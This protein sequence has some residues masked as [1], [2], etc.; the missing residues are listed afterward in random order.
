MGLTDWE[1]IEISKWYWF[2]QFRGVLLMVR[3]FS[4]LVCVA[5]M[6]S[7]SQAALLNS[8]LL[9]KYDFTADK[10]ATYVLPG[11]VAEDF[12]GGGAVTAGAGTSGY[13][14]H[15]ST[16][17]SASSGTSIGNVSLSTSIVGYSLIID[18]V[19][20]NYRANGALGGRTLFAIVRDPSQDP[21][22]NYTDATGS[23]AFSPSGTFRS[24]NTGFF[25][26][27]IVGLTEEGAGESALQVEVL[28]YMSTAGATA[29]NTRFVIDSIEVYGSVVP[30]PASIAIFGFLGAGAVVRRLR[31]KN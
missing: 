9:A 14:T 30:E 8:Y 13:Y 3:I 18:R 25:N 22:V 5:A 1:K 26:P 19:V 17:G 4:F 20:V 28:G 10:T 6:V 15:N 29:L 11:V 27:E 31:R 12:T 21:V 23:Q 2:T 7:S 16:T 24:F